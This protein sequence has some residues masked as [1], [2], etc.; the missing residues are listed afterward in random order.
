VSGE[1]RKEE[2]A[3]LLSSGNCDYINPRA[4]DEEMAVSKTLDAV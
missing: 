4:I 3:T 2:N 1:F